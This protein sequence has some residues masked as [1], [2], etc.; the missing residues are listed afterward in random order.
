MKVERIVRSGQISRQR[1][2]RSSTLP[3]LRRPPHRLQHGRARVLERDVEIGE[4]L[5]LGHQRDDLVDMRVGIDV[6][7]PHPGAELAQSS[8]R[9]RGS[10]RAPRRRARGWPHSAG[11]RR[12][13][14]CPARSPAARCT[15]ASTSASASASTSAGR[16][17]DEVA[18]QL[19]DD[20]E[21]AAI[22]AAF[23][24]LQIG[25]VLRRQSQ[26]LRRHELEEGR[27]RRRHRLVHGLEHGVVLVRP[28]DRQDL[29]VHG[30]D[31][32]RRRR[33]GSR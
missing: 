3:W 9:G 33:R 11:R 28:G 10:G 19:R 22:V 14:W 31:R 27:V 1:R 21:R 24:D 2:M 16:A 8:R 6:V 23:G 4:D 18:A 26:A 15:P 5:A 20:A 29:R 32:S 13:R 17:R 25:V 30:A 7:Q 12:R